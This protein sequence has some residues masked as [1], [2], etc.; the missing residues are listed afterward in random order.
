MAFNGGETE[1]GLKGNDRMER[2]KLGRPQKAEYKRKYGE[3]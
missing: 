1:Q 3:E 2:V